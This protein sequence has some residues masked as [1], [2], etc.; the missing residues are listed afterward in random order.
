MCRRSRDSFAQQP[1]KQQASQMTSSSTNFLECIQYES[2]H[3]T[4]LPAWASKTHSYKNDYDGAVLPSLTTSAT[5]SITPTATISPETFVSPQKM[6][7]FIQISFHIQTTGPSTAFKGSKAA[8]PRPIIP[9]TRE[10][11]HLP[12]PTSGL[13]VLLSSLESS[14]GSSIPFLR[15]I[16]LPPSHLK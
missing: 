15:L 9:F 6:G 14:C 13:G 4:S 7:N 16:D 11:N 3:A 5:T 8:V 1:R 2:Q 12:F 10:I